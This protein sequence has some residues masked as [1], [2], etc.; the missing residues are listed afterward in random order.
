MFWSMA[1]WKPSTLYDS[2]LLSGWIVL[3]CLVWGQVRVI[4][5]SVLSAGYGQP[6]D[7]NFQ[8]RRWI[9]V[10]DSSRAPPATRRSSPQSWRSCSSPDRRVLGGRGVGK[11]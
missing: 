7:V 2:E 5:R 10:F 1:M 8:V 3:D 6:S 11:H 4:D 9:V